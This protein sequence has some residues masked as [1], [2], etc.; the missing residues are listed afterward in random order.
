MHDFM[1]HVVSFSAELAEGV[2]LTVAKRA[3]GGWDVTVAGKAPLQIEA[4]FLSDDDAKEGAYRVA[5]EHLAVH[6]L[7]AIESLHLLSWTE[8]R[9]TE[10]R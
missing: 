6:G 10:S 2:L 5:A 4:S 8:E 1:T 9:I 7:T 3:L